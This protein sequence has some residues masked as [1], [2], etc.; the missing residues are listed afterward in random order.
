MLKCFTS[1]LLINTGIT[2]NMKTKINRDHIEII[3]MYQFNNNIEAA[4]Y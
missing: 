1:L 4:T 2:I 3:T